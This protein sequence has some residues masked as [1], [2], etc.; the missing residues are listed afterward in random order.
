MKFSIKFPRC[1]VDFYSFIHDYSILDDFVTK[2]C[3]L[4]CRRILSDYF[5]QVEF[6]GAVALEN[7]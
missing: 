7:A 2:K 3:W 4:F 6:A 1:F 5:T